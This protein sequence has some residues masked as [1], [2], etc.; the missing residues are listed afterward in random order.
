[1][2]Q[3]DPAVLRVLT[4]AQGFE[5]LD[6]EFLARVAHGAANAISAVPRALSG[7]AVAVA[8]RF[9]CGSLGSDTG[10]SLRLPAAANGLVGLKPTY[11]HECCQSS[12]VPRRLMNR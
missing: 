6:G 1:M 12:P 4:G 7:S 8:A 2:S 5:D 3:L 11:A 10:G 9:A